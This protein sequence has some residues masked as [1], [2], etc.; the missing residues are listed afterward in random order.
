LKR[1]RLLIPT[2][3][4]KVAAALPSF[5]IT[6]TSAVLSHCRGLSLQRIGQ[7]LKRRILNLDIR[8]QRL[9]NQTR[10]SGELK[11]VP[12]CTEWRRSKRSTQRRRWPAKLEKWSP[13]V[14]SS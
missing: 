11:N 13:M 10:L 3:A 9:A 8:D 14:R 4:P 12:R 7:R 2:T 6:K 5:V 1:R